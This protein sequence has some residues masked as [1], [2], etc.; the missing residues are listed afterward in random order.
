M[1]S[2]AL[3]TLIAASLSLV[4]A[5]DTDPLSID[6]PALETMKGMNASW[7]AEKMAMNGVPMTIKTFASNRS[8]EKVLA[9]YEKRWLAAGLKPRR[10]EFGEYDTI[11]AGDDDVY[12]S[13]QVRDAGGGSDGRITVSQPGFDANTSTDFPL[14]RRTETVSKIDSIDSGT[15]AESI[16]AYAPGG[17]L[18]NINW[19]E[20]ELGRQGWSKDPYM[21][22]DGAAEK[23][24]AFQRNSELCQ[25]TLVPNRPGYRGKTMLVIHWIK[26]VNG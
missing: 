12:F 6:L 9:F 8:A 25:L 18:E 21:P 20:R 10:A 24:I 4:C 13:I 3:L 5:A 11:G 22:D 2:R 14:P 17:P 16:V 15:R 19:F 1:L 26:G 7:A 23:I